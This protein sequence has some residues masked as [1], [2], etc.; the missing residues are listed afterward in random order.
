[1]V[2][3]A[4]PVGLPTPVSWRRTN[5]EAI[6]VAVFEALRA[7]PSAR[8]SLE[9]L[10]R[11]LEEAVSGRSVASWVID[12]LLYAAGAAFLIAWSGGALWVVTKF[13]LL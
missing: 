4:Y 2:A 3:G 5:L 7:E 10:A 11:G 1:M 12:G 9:E 13:D 8:P 6:D